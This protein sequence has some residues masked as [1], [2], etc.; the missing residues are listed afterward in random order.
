M[1]GNLT[2]RN[3]LWY[4][5]LYYKTQD[6][7]HKQKWIS[8]GLKERGN[9]KEAQRILQ[10]KIAEFANLENKS[11]EKP[12]TNTNEGKIRW[13]VWLQDYITGIKETLSPYV[14]Y[15]YNTSYMGIFKLYWEE[16]N[17][18]LEDMKT[19][20]II[21]FYNYLKDERKV[22]NITVKHYSNILRPAIKKAY[23]E[24]RLAENIYDFM[25]AIKRERSH[26]SFY[27][28]NELEILLSAVKNEKIGLPIKILA[29]YGFRRS[30]LLGLRWEAIDFT[31]KTISIN[32]KVIVSQKEVY[33][34]DTLKTASSARTLPLMPDIEKELLKWKEQQ[35]KDEEYWGEAY[36]KK[37]IGYIFLHETGDLML[38]DY[39]SHAF[40][41]V[42]K[43]NNLRHIRLHDLRHSCASL[44]LANG[45]PMKEIQDWLGHSDYNV[46]AN[47]YSHLDFS[48]KVQSA[49]KISAA[50]GKKDTK[51]NKIQELKIKLKDA[52][53]SS[54]DELI[55]LLK[56]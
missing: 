39:L 20:D 51:E 30:E 2:L 7:T 54:V 13:L 4:C 32:H 50:L 37:Y 46:T 43:K 9:K 18:Y 24:K 34:T 35:K 40:Q 14:F 33:L 16:T 19:E 55:K 15:I 49:E 3:G 47:T 48:M 22:K 29:Y 53:I 6:G 1:T 42:L 41:K 25:P 36:N 27:D 17:P 12:L 28:Q 23:V 5:V 45:I 31:N 26:V 21:S 44:L 8:T 11:A 38:P 56:D 52:G 10:E